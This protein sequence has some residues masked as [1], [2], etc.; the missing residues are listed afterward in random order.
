M[1]EAVVKYSIN[2]HLCITTVLLCQTNCF[3]MSDF[4]VNFDLL[5]GISLDECGKE[6]DRMEEEGKKERRQA[7]IDE[8]LKSWKSQDH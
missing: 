3:K 8:T 6:M 2:T 7:E 1:F 4:V 5:G